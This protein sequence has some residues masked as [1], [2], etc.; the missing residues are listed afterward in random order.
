[1]WESREALAF[2][3]V[4]FLAIRILTDQFEIH[5]FRVLSVNSFSVASFY[6]LFTQFS[7]W[8]SLIKFR[9]EL[10]IFTVSH[11]FKCACL[12]SLEVFSTFW[13]VSRLAAIVIL[14]YHWTSKSRWVVLLYWRQI[15]RFPR[16]IACFCVL[17]RK[18]QTG[19][20][21]WR[22]SLVYRISFV[23]FIFKLLAFRAPFWTSRLRS[24]V[25]RLM[26]LFI[27]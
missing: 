11:E 12:T 20:L 22:L 24:R 13:S 3:Y 15:K 1:M 14:N 27:S 18:G 21:F 25:R 8:P 2:F 9:C 23:I 26:Q 19:V 4:I 10:F 16:H 6:S 7:F 5:K 17:L